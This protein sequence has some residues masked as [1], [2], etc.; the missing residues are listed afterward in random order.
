MYEG[1]TCLGVD[2]HEQRL[3]VAIS[4]PGQREIEIESVAN[5]PKSLKRWSER[6]LKAHG[7]HVLCVYESGAGG[8]ALQRQLRGWGLSCEVAAASLIP[9]GKGRLK[10]DRRDARSLVHQLR[11]GSLHF[12]RT[13]TEN[14]EALRELTRCRQSLSEMVRSVRHRI[15]KMLLRHDLRY[16]DGKKKWTQGFR[17]W[18]SKLKFSE[19]MSQEALQELVGQLDLLEQRLKNL[20]QRLEDM[21]NDEFWGPAVLGLSCLRGIKTV[22]AVSLAAEFGD[23]RSFPRAGQ[24][25]AWTGL[26]PSEASSGE[27]K[28]RGSITLAGNGRVRRLLIESAWHARQPISSRAAVVKR[29]QNQPAAIVTMAQKS[30]IRLNSR[31]HRLCHR[32]KPSPVATVAVAREMV[33]TVWAI[34]REVELDRQKKN[35]VDGTVS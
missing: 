21:K 2:W 13:P 19:P 3:V 12:V 34:L 10:T 11:A 14:Q 33:G 4:I 22:T 25:M 15:S 28:K 29:R 23:V 24:L 9:T 26:V 7:P 18:L 31:F 16:L 20:D 8:Y 27:R 30:E 17:K 5:E 1:I 6:L 32:G 35:Q